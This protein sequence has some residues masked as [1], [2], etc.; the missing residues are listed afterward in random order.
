VSAVLLVD[1]TG[2]GRPVAEIVRQA[3]LPVKKLVPI[4]ITAGHQVKDAIAGGGW[5]VPKKDLVGAVKATLERGRLLIAPG[6][7][8]AKTLTKELKTFR[9]KVSAATGNETLE[10]WRERD[11]DDLV[12]AVAMVTWYGER[13]QRRLW[14]HL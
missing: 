6:A 10:A 9:A 14:V 8:E 5:N 12:L 11:H 13:A 1:A 4:T 7:P 3:K 2:V